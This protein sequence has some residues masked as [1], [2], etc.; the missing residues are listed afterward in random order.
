[1]ALAG[2]EARVDLFANVE[3]SRTVFTE[4]VCASSP[5]GSN[6]SVL[7]VGAHLDSVEAG[8]GMN[9]DGS[10]SIGVLEIALKASKLLR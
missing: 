10:G 7:V 6:T 1:M 8:P 5:F 3:A 2:K 4:S 9:D